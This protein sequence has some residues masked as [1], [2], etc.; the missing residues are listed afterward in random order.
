[1]FEGDY[2]EAILTGAIGWGKSTFAE[3]A[4]CR[5]L[6]EISC[7]RDPQKV[8]GLMKGS[9]IVLL[10]VGVTLDNA[11]KVVFQGIKS[12]LHTSP[13]FNN[14]FPFDAW[15]NELR[16]PNNIWVF[17]AVAGSN[18]VIGY[19][20]FGGVMDEVNFMSIVENSKSVASGGKYDQADLLYKSLIRRMKSRFMKRGKL[21]VS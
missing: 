5:M 16:F 15:K 3:I 7:L 12:K 18:G 11:R 1:M 4:M 10:N 20:V 14:E 17:P 19:N 21:P 6:Y 8:Y 9:V 2:V 13:Y